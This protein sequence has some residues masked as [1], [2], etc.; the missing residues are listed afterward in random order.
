MHVG[1]APVEEAADN[2]T[3]RLH[4]GHRTATVVALMEA[5]AGLVKLTRQ[6]RSFAHLGTRQR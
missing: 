6:R 4:G 5:S 2:V 1:L 3:R